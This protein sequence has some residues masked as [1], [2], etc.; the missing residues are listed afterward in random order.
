[1][2]DHQR[3]MDGWMTKYSHLLQWG[4][5]SAG[6]EVVGEAMEMATDALWK[7]DEQFQGEAEGGAPIGRIEMVMDPAVAKLF[8]CWA[9]YGMAALHQRIEEESERIL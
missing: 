2:A 9:A 8:T 1:M 4:V 7:L 6:E 5:D 3:A